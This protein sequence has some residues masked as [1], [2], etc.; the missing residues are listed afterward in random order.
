MQEA[1]RVAWLYDTQV[2]ESI[3]NSSTIAP[4]VLEGEA[5]CA[6]P[7]TEYLRYLGVYKE[8][9]LVGVFLFVRRLKYMWE[10]HTCLMPEC[11]GKLAIVAGELAM[12]SLFSATEAECL[13]TFVPEEYLHVQA[14]TKR[15]GFTLLGIM[16]Q[17]FSHKGQQQDCYFYAIT[18]EEASI[19]LQQL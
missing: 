1:I 14:Y 13:T 19:C 6:A 2:V 16:P 18:R 4:F 9:N 10:V 12:L 5:F 17:C 15:M 11:R 3:V 8:S 7:P